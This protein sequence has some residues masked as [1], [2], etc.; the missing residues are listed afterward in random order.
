MQ[1][2]PIEKQFRLA[3]KKRYPKMK[4][5]DQ[6]QV[7]RYR[8]DFAYPS[9]KVAIELD[10][11]A[12]HSSTTDIANDRRRQREIERLGWRFIRFGGQEVYRD[13]DACARETYAF[14]KKHG[15]QS[16]LSKIWNFLFSREA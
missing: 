1:E 14:I 7:G 12:T 4:L 8:L 2:S 15:N 10:G 13:A 9:L 5:I 6:Y 11:H 16:M 3:W